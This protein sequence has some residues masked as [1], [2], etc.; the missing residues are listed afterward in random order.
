VDD[1]II[2]VRDYG[3]M[4]TDGLD[5]GAAI[6]AAMDALST[7]GGIVFF[8]RGDYICDSRTLSLPKGVSLI[9]EGNTEGFPANGRG[10]AIRR[11]G[12]AGVLINPVNNSKFFISTLLLSSTGDVIDM[13]GT[14]NSTLTDLTLS[15][16]TG[17]WCIYTEGNTF[18]AVYTDISV[19]GTS[20]PTTCHG[21]LLNSHTRLEGYHA[22]G[23]DD[24]IRIFGPAMQCNIASCRIEVCNDAFVIGRDYAGALSAASGCSISDVSTESCL[25][26]FDILLAVNCHIKN[27]NA[28][29]LAAGAVPMGTI[30]GGIKI[31]SLSRS[32][33]EDVTVSIEID[34]QPV[35]EL[36]SISNCLFNRVSATNVDADGTGW[37]S[38][39]IYTTNATNNVFT[40]CNIPLSLSDTL[41]NDSIF[42]A[43]RT[44]SLL[45]ADYLNAAK[46]GKNLRGINVP[47][48]E[49]AS[50]KAVIFS[51]AVESG[52]NVPTSPAAAVTGGATLANGTYYYL[53]S[54]VTSSGEARGNTEAQVVV[55]G[56]NNSVTMTLGGAPGN[57]VY[58]K[59]VYRGTATGVY[60]GC[61][62][63]A[64]NTNS[65]TDTGAAFTIPGQEP[66]ADGIGNTCV[67]PDTNYAVIVT[68]NWLTT[69]R[70]T[71]KATTGFTVD[72]GTAAPAG[73]TFDYFIVR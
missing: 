40:G 20:T 69:H 17:C 39:P 22:V 14:N 2:S 71:S 70:V 4:P 43:V 27:V 15:A 67:E 36:G 72:F 21:V 46:Q 51:P 57:A 63:L 54:A 8:P 1:T 37:Q 28:T 6:Q 3:A 64:L 9:G 62:E 48:T 31:T 18:D 35:I 68:P 10:S 42:S 55:S 52:N 7:T 34:K 25:R 29:G 59:R 45:A 47:V 60:D 16:G 13:T 44:G 23:V 11:T 5:D 58:K 24:A 41:S 32:T 33:I 49:T 73:A 19:I 56:A 50:T 26:T 61:Y 38:A 65:F 12:T 53:V 66:P 30:N